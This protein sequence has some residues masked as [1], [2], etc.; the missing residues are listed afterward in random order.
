[1]GE[2]WKDLEDEAKGYRDRANSIADKAK[3]AGRELSKTEQEEF[4]NLRGKYEITSRLAKEAKDEEIARLSELTG[5]PMSATVGD[6]SGFANYVKTGK[7][8]AASMSS[9]DGNGGYVLPR[10]MVESIVEKMKATDPIFGGA[11][12]F[13]L[14]GSHKLE[15]PVQSALGAVTWVGETTARPETNSP[16][17]A[18]IELVTYD[19]YADWRGTELFL[20]SVPDIANWIVSEMTGSIFDSAATKFA[21]GNGSSEI[22]GLFAN[23]SS[24]YT[25]RLSG[26]SGAL[27]NTAFLSAYADLPAQYH[28]NAAWV[29]KPA[30]FG[31]VLTYAYPNTQTPL[32]QFVNGQPT[33]LGKPVL[34]CDNAPAVGASNYPVFFGDLS[35]AYAVGLHHRVS[36]LRDDYTAAPYIRFYGRMRVGGIPRDNQAGVLI[37]SHN[38]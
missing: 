20:D 15:I 7:I 38:A 33:I 16:T 4:E 21:V 1:M 28:R 8:Q 13:M 36:I 18:N 26:S 12:L 22:S 14:E 9:V 11:R 37:K 3:Q 34:L 17:F 35:Q 23:T 19:V 30:T 2:K 5:T 31:T 24:G 6:S 25:V 10:P 27:V 29:M 32:V